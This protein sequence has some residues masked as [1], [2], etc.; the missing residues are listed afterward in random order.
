MPSSWSAANDS[1]PMP[2][3]SAPA[4]SMDLLRKG[5][6]E[7]AAALSKA[8]MEHQPAPA[9]TGQPGTAGTSDSI[10]KDAAGGA[11]GLRRE[12]D[13]LAVALTQASQ[14]AVSYT[15]LD[16]YKRQAIFF[17]NMIIWV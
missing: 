15:H 12:P 5:H 8:K 9:F 14:E 2:K 16:V 13:E 7:L 6:D 10:G 4:G 11:D 3:R 1:T 17:I